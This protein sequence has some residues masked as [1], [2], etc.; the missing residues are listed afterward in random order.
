MLTGCT[1]K[2]AQLPHLKPDRQAGLLPFY[3]AHPV[4]AGDIVL[5]VTEQHRMNDL[6]DIMEETK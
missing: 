1:E 5:V 2:T 3:E 4:S 6:D